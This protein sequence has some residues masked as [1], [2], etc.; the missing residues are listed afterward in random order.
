MAI[1]FIPVP[2]DVSNPDLIV[3][4]GC[5]KNALIYAPRMNTDD[6]RYT[7]KT[8]IMLTQKARTKR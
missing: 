7:K 6:R 2:D 1:S 5:L 8:I 4:I 3:L